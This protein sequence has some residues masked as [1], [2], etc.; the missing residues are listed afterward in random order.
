MS[1]GYH[2]RLELRKDL[3]AKYINM[4]IVNISVVIC[5]DLVCSFINK[6]K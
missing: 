3:F 4:R 1:V 6:N 5:V 2:F